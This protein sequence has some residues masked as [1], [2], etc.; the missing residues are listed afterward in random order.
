MCGKVGCSEY[1]ADSISLGVHSEMNQMWPRLWF[2]SV[3]GLSVAV[4]VSP[5]MLSPLVQLAQ[6]Y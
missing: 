6:V 5:Q 2:K 1:V 4:T 3:M